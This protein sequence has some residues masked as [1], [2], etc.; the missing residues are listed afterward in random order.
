MVPVTDAWIEYETGS[1]RRRLRVGALV[2]NRDQIDS[3][4][5]AIDEWVELPDLPFQ[6]GGS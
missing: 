6:A 5:N 3:V 2:V 4:T 1:E